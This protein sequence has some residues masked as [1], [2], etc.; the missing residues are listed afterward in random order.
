MSI[1]VVTAGTPLST[2]LTSKN[3]NEIASVVNRASKDGTAYGVGDATA[4]RAAPCAWCAETVGA[5]MAVVPKE[6]TD[7]GNFWTYGGGAIEVEIYSQPS[8][9][10]E[11]EP[12][13]PHSGPIGVALDDASP[14]MTFPVAF[15][16]MAAV[17]VADGPEQF[18]R[19]IDGGLWERVEVSAFPIVAENDDG[20][21]AWIILDAPTPNRKPAEGV[22]VIDRTLPTDDEKGWNPFGDPENPVPEDWQDYVAVELIT[23]TPRLNAG[24]LE[25]VRVSQTWAAANA[26][27]I[28]ALE[29]GD[30]VDA[31]AGCEE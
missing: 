17:P 5:G 6:V 20:D 24:A 12:S 9:E 2:A 31:G 26:P 22:Y 29:D 18:V 15:V 28:P 3:W 21:W 11:E 14:G 27:V 1:P 8:E 23:Q 30:V 4:R 13:P 7:P 16:G 19:P 10:E 25:F